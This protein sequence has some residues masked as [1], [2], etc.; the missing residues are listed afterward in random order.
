MENLSFNIEG[1]SFV[2]IQKAEQMRNS[3][4]AITTETKKASDVSNGWTNTMK[5][6]FDVIGGMKTLKGFA[7]DVIRVR[8]EI[9]QLEISFASL[10]QSKEKANILVSQM[11]A[12]AAQSPFELK[13]LSVGAKQLIESGVATEQVNET[14]LRLGDIALGVGIPLERLAGLYGMVVE[15]GHLYSDDLNQFAGAGIPMLES[16]ASILGVTI[17]QIDEMVSIGKIG[18]PEVQKVVESLTNEGGKFYGLV[19]EQS[20]T[21]AG[22]LNNV[23]SAWDA[24]FNAVGESQ[25]DVINNSLDG[26]KYVLENYEQLGR[27]VLELAGVYGTYQAV[28]ISLT[29]FQKLHK[30]VVEQ[31]RLEMV[32][33]AKSGEIL[34]KSQAMSAA[35]TKLFTGAIKSNTAAL[36]KNPYV[37]VAAAIVGLGYSIYKVTTAETEL[38]KAHKRLGSANTDV[39]KSLSSEISKLS[40]LEKKLV[41]VKKG[42]EEYNDIKKNIVDNYGQYYKGLDEEIERVGNL[43]T[44]YSQLVENMRLTIGQRKFES[45]FKAEQDSLD[46]I[47]SGKLEKAYETLVEKY[48]KTKGVNLYDQFFDSTMHGTALSSDVSEELRKATFWEI[49]WGNNAEDGIV[50]FKNNVFNLRSEIKKETKATEVILDEYKD[51]FKITDEEVTQILFDK[52]NK[53]EVEKNKSLDELIRNIRTTEKSIMELRKN[54]Q[55]GVGDDNSLK[56]RITELGELKESYRIKTGFDYDQKYNQNFQSDDNEG[57]IKR[58]REQQTL[59]E[60]NFMEDMKNRNAQAEIDAKEEGDEK[61]LAQLKFNHQKEIDE[62]E[63]FKADYLQKKIDTEKA[64]FEADTEKNKGKSFDSSKISLNQEEESMFDNLKNQTLKKQGNETSLYYKDLLSKYQGYTEKRLTLEDK[65]KKER[66]SLV[67]AGAS[68]ETLGEHDFQKEEA[69]KAVDSEFAMREDSFKAWTD[70][71][72]NLSLEELKKSL[73]QAEQELQRSQFLHPNDPNLAV[74]RS[75]ITSLKNEVNERERE[76]KPSPGKRSIEE[77]QNLYQ[78]LSKVEREFDEIGAAVGGTAGEIISAAGGITSSTLQM[79][80]GIMTLA[81]GSASAMSSTSQAASKSIQT[82]EKASVILAIIGAALQI[83]TKIANMFGADY[84]D[85]NAAKENYENYVKVLDVVIGKQKE[86]L[87]TLTGKAAVEASQSALGL[88]EKQANAARTLGKERLNA[89]A[90]AGS[91][92]IGVRI[93]DNMSREGWNE[94]EKAIGTSAYNQIRDGRMTGLFDLSVEQLEKL[95]MEAPTFWAKLDGDVSDYLEQIIACND[96]T[97]EMHDLLNQ[98]LTQTSFDDVYSSFLDALSDMGTSSEEFADN[99]EK[100]LQKAILNSMLVDKYK[101]RINT[102]YEAFAKANDDEAGITTA[103]YENLQRDWNDIVSGAIAE[104]NALMEQFDWSSESSSSQSSNQTGFAAMSQD[105]GEE[106]N[107]RFTALQ[108]SNEEIKNSMLFVLGSLSSLCTT[109]SDGNILLMEMR[110]LAVMS[111]GHLEDIAKYTKVM[112]GF[113]EKLDNIDRNTQKI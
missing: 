74:Q 84:S 25:E 30:S 49:K 10:L 23:S 60:V 34:T 113:G 54:A 14:L 75:K 29:A 35:G 111:N 71:I 24:M 21:I 83:A 86:L 96:K 52:S 33:A 104:R 1:N 20:K 26:V 15:Q 100:Y 89:G 31:A 80:D 67:K 9:Q 27:T 48:G 87:E 41:E 43:S 58:I 37:F 92:S 108:I 38:E 4:N 97:E 47:V 16:L 13:T 110:N 69:L 3:I 64:I 77:W 45:F 61:K 19:D 99:F 40:S 103:E 78:T 11:I 101:S 62:L 65:F 8:S 70:N 79:I 53:K 63:K 55:K 32:L 85:Y 2:F 90:S 102:W 109:A 106:L 59:D 72:A 44:V 93:K 88:I 5:K 112:L 7:D 98:S 76:T 66:D 81:T 50:D 42:S 28:L 105:T 107:G 17:E 91:H 82:V 94:A 73:F 57:K 46:I 6:A 51:K 18:F 36:L 39:E 12:V 56:E 22:K 68:K 95:Q